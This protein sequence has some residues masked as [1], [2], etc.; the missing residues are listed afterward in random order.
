MREASLRCWKCGVEPSDAEYLAGV[1]RWWPWIPALQHVCAGC[2]EKEEIQLEDDSVFL[3]YV[4]AAGTAHFSHMVTVMV[5]GLRVKRCQD[6]LEIH[7][8]GQSWLLT[9]EAQQA[10][11]GDAGNPRA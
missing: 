7:L 2:G 8:R 4:Y 11:A 6:S 10:A 1:S 3:G 5:Q 9:A